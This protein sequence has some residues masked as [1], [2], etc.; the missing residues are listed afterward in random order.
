MTFEESKESSSSVGPM[1]STNNLPS[2]T[3]EDNTLG[4][5]TGEGRDLEE[6]IGADPIS[7]FEEDLEYRI[8]D[9]IHEL[10]PESRCKP[11]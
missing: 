3:A 11:L 6:Q 7:E 10:Q 2:S 9:R 1:S 5:E 4:S 8:E